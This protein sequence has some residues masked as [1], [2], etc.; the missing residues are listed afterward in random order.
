[1]PQVLGIFIGLSEESLERN[2]FICCQGLYSTMNVLMTEALNI[3][4]L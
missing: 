4:F 3:V 2:I 1:M